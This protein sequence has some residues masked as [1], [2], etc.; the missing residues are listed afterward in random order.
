[1]LRQEIFWKRVLPAQVH[2]G[3]RPLVSSLTIRHFHGLH[4][5]VQNLLAH[6]NPVGD[7]PEPMRIRTEMSTKLSRAMRFH[8]H[9]TPTHGS[10]NASTSRSWAQSQSRRKQDDGSTYDDGA[11]SDYCT[12]FQDASPVASPPS[13]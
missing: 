13:R 9:I 5:P 4:Q 3:P 8:G 1:M 10:G 11:H 12:S 6:V 2:K 7:I